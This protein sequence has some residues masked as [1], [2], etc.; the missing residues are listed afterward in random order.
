[1]LTPPT[2]AC[3]PSRPACP[4]ATA[5]RK[6]AQMLV[7][8][9]AKTPAGSRGS[10]PGLLSLP[11]EIL[12]QVVQNLDHKDLQGLFQEA[13]AHAAA[14]GPPPRHRGTA[15]WN[16]AAGRRGQK[17]NERGPPG[18]GARLCLKPTPFVGGGSFLY[19]MP[20]SKITSMHPLKIRNNA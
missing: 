5:G 3:S 1:M 17:H 10:S 14:A 20:F 4:T 8:Q 6:S 15:P 16:S 13:R 18:P 9:L 11:P 19:L 2:R 7:E 12:M